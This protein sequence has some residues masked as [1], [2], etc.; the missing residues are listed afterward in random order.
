VSKSKYDD[1]KSTNNKY[2]GGYWFNPG[3]NNKNYWFFGWV[4]QRQVTKSWWVG[5]ETFYQTKTKRDEHESF[6]FNIGGGVTLQK[7]WQIIYSF[8]R[9]TG[10]GQFLYY[11]A[12]Y[13]TW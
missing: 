7:D 12:L 8:G 1:N 5:L 11:V 2:C 10:V 4:I 3:V 6:G 13:H 9:N